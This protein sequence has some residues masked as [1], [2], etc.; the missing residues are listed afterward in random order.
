[1]LLAFALSLVSEISVAL[2]QR[3]SHGSDDFR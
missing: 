1:M 3:K 2:R